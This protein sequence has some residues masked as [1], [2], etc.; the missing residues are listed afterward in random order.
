MKTVSINGHQC[1]CEA[2]KRKIEQLVEESV[3]GKAHGQSK[4]CALDVLIC[5]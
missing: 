3:K 4:V 1:N 5:Y 2:A